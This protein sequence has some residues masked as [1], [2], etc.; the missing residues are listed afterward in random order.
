[1]FKRDFWNGLDI[2]CRD[3]KTIRYGYCKNAQYW[4]KMRGSIFDIRD[5]RLVTLISSLV[6]PRFQIVCYSKRETKLN[7]TNERC[8][9]I[10]C[11]EDDKEKLGRICKI[12]AMKMYET[13]RRRKEI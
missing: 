7:L 3:L 10:R 13:R 6:V 9:K 4:N 2:Q 12:Q 5:L 8:S 11:K 1:M